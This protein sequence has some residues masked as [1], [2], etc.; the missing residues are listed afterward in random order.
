MPV[1]SK[2]NGFASFIVGATHM[3]KISLK[4]SYKT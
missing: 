3:V 4:I 1:G 2:I